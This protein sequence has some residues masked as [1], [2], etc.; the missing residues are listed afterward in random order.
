M[1]ERLIAFILFILVSPVLFLLFLVMK[2]TSP[3]PFVFR[4][5][6]I[7]KGKR[8]FIMYKIRSMKV[9][10]DKT[11]AKLKSRNEADGPVFK[12][13]E[14]PRFTPLGRMLSRTGLDELL[15]FINIIRGEMSFVGPRPLPVVEARQIPK[16]WDARFTVNPG[17]TS[18]WVVAGSHKLTFR[19]WMESDVR[20]VKEKSIT[21]DLKVGFRTV[22]LIIRWMSQGTA[23][24]LRSGKGA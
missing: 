15:Q 21:Y 9:G 10:A 8:I 16:K 18:P 2:A 3:G 6:R 14:D 1:L 23:N 12:I 19:Q 20:Y 24:C 5:K 17:I 4:Q 11:Q 7:G 13:K 22:V